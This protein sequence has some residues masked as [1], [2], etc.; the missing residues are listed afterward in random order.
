MSKIYWVI[1]VFCVCAAPPAR[2]GEVPFAPRFIDGPTI[3]LSVTTADIDG[4]GDMDIIEGTFLT[5]IINSFLAWYENDGAETPSF[6]QHIIVHGGGPGINYES[7][8]VADMDGDNYLDVI[9]AL[10]GF[11][12]SRIEWYE[13][14]GAIPPAFTVHTLT[15]E[16]LNL[17]YDSIY[18]TDLDNDGNTDVIAASST[19]SGALNKI[20]WHKNDGADPP[21]FMEIVIPSSII[22]PRTISAE[23]MDNDNDMDVIVTSRQDGTIVWFENDGTAQPGFIEHIIG[24][25]GFSIFTIDLDSDGDIDIV[26]T[27]TVWISWYE[28]NGECPPDFTVRLVSDVPDRPILVSAADLDLDGDVDIIADSQADEIIYWFENDGASTP[29]FTLHLLASE[30]Y[31]MH[32]IHPADLNE[33]GDIDIIAGGGTSGTSSNSGALKWYEN[34]LPKPNFIRHDW[35]LYD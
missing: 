32:T 34:L 19:P 35:R 27:N 24:D 18:A 15:T 8:Q 25:A 10:G 6:T 22:G 11:T 3:P 9:V 31:S 23:D 33:D 26:S 17:P 21:S 14:N 12:G 29:G 13:N 2:G 16:A 4:D 7:V 28:N 1:L 20:A 30:S 5:F